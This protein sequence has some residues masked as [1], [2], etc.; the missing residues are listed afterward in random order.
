MCEFCLKHGEG[1]KWYLQAKNYAE[2]LLS[3]LQRRQFIRRFLSDPRGLAASV[4]RLERLEKLPPFIRGLARALV[5]RHQK[6]VHF[7][8]IVPLEEVEEIFGFVKS[9]VRVACICRQAS[10]G[11]EKRYCYGVS[12]AP[13]GGQLKEI[14]ADLD[15]SF[16]TGPDHQGLE[17]LSPQEALAALRAHEDEGLC[18]SVWTFQ[19]PFIGGICNCDRASCLA[20]RCTVSQGVAVLFRGEY[21]AQINSDLC[22][23]C[24]AC[25]GMCQFGALSYSP[26]LGKAVVDPRWCYGCGVCRVACPQE[27][28]QLLAR[29]TVPVAAHLW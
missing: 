23:G 2:D 8:Q 28:I 12:L 26:A 3:A 5:T 18:H 10:L 17:V 29:Q 22:L 11:L 25:L 20:L 19:T 24:R 6:K 9:I 14:L 4:Q 7:G 1:Q 15:G 16:L 21:V 27:A 13:D